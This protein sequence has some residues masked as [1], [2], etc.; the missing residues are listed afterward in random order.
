VKKST[1][2]FGQLSSDVVAV[3]EWVAEQPGIDKH[4]I[5]LFG[6][7]QGGWI[8]PLAA[9]KT[10][11]ISYSVILSGPVASL[12]QEKLFSSLAGDEKRNSAKTLKEVNQA[13]EEFSGAH[14]F[15]SSEE[16][17]RMEIPSFWLFGENDRSMPVQISLRNLD[18]IIQ[19]GGKK[20]FTY[21]VYPNANHS[22]Y[23]VNTEARL[24]YITDIKNW[25]SRALK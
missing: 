22:L 25:V 2:V 9:N 1:E 15:D 13:M 18:R 5:G 3:A 10:E 14:G 16:I 11:L 7:S 6:L 12:G 20:N 23:D 24:D 19:D 4:R 21:K 8:A 17:E